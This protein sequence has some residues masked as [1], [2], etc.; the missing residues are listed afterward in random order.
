[1]NLL[2][3]S[4]FAPG[5][6]S[7]MSNLIASTGDVEEEHYEEDWL[8][9]YSQGR[10]FEIYWVSLHE[11]FEGRTFQEI[12]Q[13]VYQ[14]TKAIAIALEI[15]NKSAPIIKLNPCSYWIWNIGITKYYIYLICEDKSEA[16]II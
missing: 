1:M 13:I 6:I 5:L 10:G 3:K 2:A 9:D 14:E 4:C 11:L 16:D 15:E 8:R 12:V 7:L